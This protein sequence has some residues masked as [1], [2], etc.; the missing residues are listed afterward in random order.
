MHSKWVNIEQAIVKQGNAQN[1]TVCRLGCNFPC[2]MAAD[3]DVCFRGVVPFLPPFPGVSLFRL[4]SVLRVAT[5]SPEWL[6]NEAA[7]SDSGRTGEWVRTPSISSGQKVDEK[8]MLL[9]SFKLFPYRRS[10]LPLMKY[11][12]NRSGA[13]WDFGTDL[14]FCSAGQGAFNWHPLSFY[15][16]SIT[17]FSG[18]QSNSLDHVAGVQRPLATYDQQF[19]RCL[20]AVDATRCGTQVWQGHPQGRLHLELSPCSEVTWRLHHYKLY[21]E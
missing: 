4:S 20:P 2:R 15:Y 7:A 17:S 18:H 13:F 19:V 16:T 1:T 5:R 14:T 8:F 21:F 6:D 12:Q 10:S 11:T 9:S 3:V